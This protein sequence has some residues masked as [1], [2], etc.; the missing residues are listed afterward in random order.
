[1]IKL[2]FNGKSKFCDE[3]PCDL[4]N[5]AQK[6]HESF[7]ITHHDLRFSYKDCNEERIEIEHQRD[8]KSAYK[9]TK[10]CKVPVLNILIESGHTNIKKEDTTP[11]P[12]SEINS[13]Q[14][15]ARR[16]DELQTPQKLPIS[17]L[18][19]ETPQLPKINEKPL[20]EFEGFIYKLSGKSNDTVYYK[21]EDSKTL[22]CR[23]M[24]KVTTQ[25]SQEKMSLCKPH[26]V[27]IKEHSFFQKCFEDEN[28]ARKDKKR[29]KKLEKQK[30]IKE[31]RLKEELV[32]AETL[33]QMRKDGE[34]VDDDG[35]L[36]KAPQKKD[37]INQ[38]T[39]F[40]ETEDHCDED[41]CLIDIQMIIDECYKEDPSSNRV[42]VLANIAQ[43]P[44]MVPI[45][46]KK[47]VLIEKFLDEAERK[48][49]D[50]VKRTMNRPFLAAQVCPSILDAQKSKKEIV[51]P[52]YKKHKLKANIMVPVIPRSTI[53][54]S[55]PHMDLSNIKSYSGT[56][57]GRAYHEIP[58][59]GHMRKFMFLVSDFEVKMLRTNLSEKS[60]KNDD[61]YNLKIRSLHMRVF[62]TCKSPLLC[63]KMKFLHADR[64]YPYRKTCCRKFLHL[65]CL[66]QECLRTKFKPEI[67]GIDTNMELSTAVQAA[68]P[69]A[70]IFTTHLD[71][72]RQLWKMIFDHDM[73]IDHQITP[74]VSHLVC[75]IQAISFLP[76]FK[77]KAQIENLKSH[78]SSK[79]PEELMPAFQ[80]FIENFTNL[81]GN[82]FTNVES[83]NQSILYL[84]HRDLLISI[85]KSKEIC[86][87]EVIKATNWTKNKGRNVLLMIETARRIERGLKSKH[88]RIQAPEGKFD[89][90]LP[91][92]KIFEKIIKLNIKDFVDSKITPPKDTL[93]DWSKVKYLRITDP[94]VIKDKLGHNMKMTDCF[95]TRKN[96][97]R[98]RK[99]KRKQ[100]Y[101]P[102]RSNIPE[103]TFNSEVVQ[104]DFTTPAGQCVATID[105]SVNQVVERE[106][107]YIAERQGLTSHDIYSEDSDELREE[108]HRNMALQ[109][110][111]QRMLGKSK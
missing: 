101:P 43:I 77:A 80:K 38:I 65:L 6:A 35:N 73:V 92:T 61:R 86:M 91:F 34:P 85:F 60:Q 57:F 24:L 13:N 70:F 1:M 10:L 90:I 111:A 63:Q 95:Q 40:Q 4:R 45:L 8:L 33:N 74:E 41:T 11:V 69:S 82:S 18:K 39:A 94:P 44:K 97:L 84:K 52:Y 27:D 56:V 32:L 14:L 42:Q 79:I 62:N 102:K 93:A 71:F 64:P 59:K 87:N 49:K 28:Q 75:C 2:S 106:T 53:A 68:F 21:C 72:T 9:F 26:S 50:R 55:S 17:E 88:S 83:W 103:L 51:N 107:D 89:P 25:N 76:P 98:L 3:T 67:I 36:F 108:H 81:Y 37:L 48:G 30:K 105:N 12:L 46:N 47:M 104:N 66:V 20:I 5:L 29:L 19:S 109:T 78:F 23:G 7:N 15:A 54:R 96:K 31:E 58:I 110:L 100:K 99:L 22:K 16:S